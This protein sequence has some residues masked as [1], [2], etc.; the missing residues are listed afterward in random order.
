MQVL[1][2]VIGF[3][4]LFVC[5]QLGP[6]GMS[7]R[8]RQQISD[9]CLSEDISGR[10]EPHALEDWL[11]DFY[12]GMDDPDQDAE[13]E[14]FGQA[15][16]ASKSWSARRKA[17][18]NTACLSCMSSELMSATPIGMAFAIAAREERDDLRVTV[19]HVFM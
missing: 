6:C 11:G 18:V 9:S 1:R 15:D 16:T 5:R 2:G 13:G 12:S 10:K 3:A 17:E 7:G 4:M 14:N 8:L 19:A